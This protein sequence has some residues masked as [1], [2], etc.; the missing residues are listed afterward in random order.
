MK[1]KALIL[2]ILFFNIVHAKDISIDEISLYS[3]SG[4]IGGY[5]VKG[6]FSS[7][8]SN[9]FDLQYYF[10]TKY[11][12][13][14]FKN[15]DENFKVLS[16]DKDLGKIS[17]TWENASKKLDFKFNTK[18]LQDKICSISYISTKGT[19][20]YERIREDEGKI[21]ASFDYSSNL[22]Y[23]KPLNMA[24]MSNIEGGVIFKKMSEQ[25]AINVLLKQ[26]ENFL[27]DDENEP[28]G[29]EDSTFIDLNF[30]NDS[31]MFITIF[32][33]Y[34][35]SSAVHPSF[36]T[37]GYMIDIANERLKTLTLGDIV[38]DNEKS[39]KLL[40]NL[41]EKHI[42]SGDDEEVSTDWEWLE[43][44]YFDDEYGKSL[45]SQEVAIKKNSVYIN[46]R[47]YLGEAGRALDDFELD[48]NALKPFAK[49]IL[50]EILG[51]GI[52]I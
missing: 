12:K 37:S 42:N 3:F 39:R 50:K 13:A 29:A 2:L 15:K 24:F 25:E 22:L 4:D 31:Y 20:S 28:Y 45:F 9:N 38:V 36:W 40:A 44:R 32:R 49:G 26:K 30:F 27:Q 34:S 7:Y 19:K 52:I 46:L 51:G 41:V 47:T 11:G 14:I 10:Y 18:C 1:R 35:Y 43:N 6:Y 33:T 8:K 23:L 5:G 21:E 48:F 16:I 17:G